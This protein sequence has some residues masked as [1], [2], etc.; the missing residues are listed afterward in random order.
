MKE[1]LKHRYKN[2]KERTKQG[3]P[4]YDV[5]QEY[6]CPNCQLAQKTLHW[7]NLKWC[8]PLCGLAVYPENLMEID[9]LGYDEFLKTVDKT[10]PRKKRARRRR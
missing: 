1:D 10:D 9:R 8:C 2:A 7:S 5:E 6:M 3:L 4:P